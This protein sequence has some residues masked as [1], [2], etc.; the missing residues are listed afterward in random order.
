M[1]EKIIKS[2]QDE[3]KAREG[4]KQEGND[5]GIYKFVQGSIMGLK[6]ALDIVA[7]NK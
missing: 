3:I 5:E 6:I 4:Y 1:D 7:D 2:I